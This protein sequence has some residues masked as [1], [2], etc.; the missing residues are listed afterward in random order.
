MEHPAFPEEK[1]VDFQRLTRRCTSR[2]SCWVL[3]CL[4]CSPPCRFGSWA[5]QPA[6]FRWQKCWVF[7]KV[8]KSMGETRA[9]NSVQRGLFGYGYEM[10]W[11]TYPT[12]PLGIVAHLR[13]AFWGEGLFHLHRYL[14]DAIWIEG[15]FGRCFFW[16][17]WDLV[18]LVGNS[19]WWNEFKELMISKLDVSGRDRPT[20]KPMDSPNAMRR[21]SLCL[22]DDLPIQWPYPSWI[23]RNY[24]RVWPLFASV[25]CCLLQN[26]EKNPAGLMQRLFFSGG[27]GPWSLPSFR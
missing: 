16:D 17:I 3:L 8:L 10:I 24:Q 15:W 20:P 11:D 6:R 25:H 23:T 27:F 14:A 13:C 2:R 18:N 5:K 19:P 12:Y 7:C 26:L 9:S 4:C 22:V 1:P 21:R